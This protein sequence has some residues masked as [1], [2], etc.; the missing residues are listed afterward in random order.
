[1]SA[2]APRASYES[3]RAYDVDAG[4][5]EIQLADNTSPFGTPPAALAAIARATTPALSQYPSTYSRPLREA[6]ARYIGVAPEQVMVGAGSDEVMSCAFR[7]LADPP[8]RVAMIE[9]TFVMARVFAIT[10]SQQVTTVPLREDFDADVE[11]LLA[12][13][14]QLVY[15]CT[16]NNPTGT[17]LTRAAIDRILH[18]SRAVVLLDEAYA[19]YAGTNYAGEAPN[20][21]R[22][23]VLRTFSKAFGMAGFRVGYAVGARPLI[24]ELE[25]ARG[26]YTVSALSEQAALAAVTEDVPWVRAGV[27]RVLDARER[28]MAGLRDA[29][30]APLPSRANFVLLPV[31]GDSADAMRALRERGIQVRHFHGLPGVGEAI[32]ISIGEWPVMQRVLATLQE[33]VPCA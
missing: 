25:K 11:G 2:F 12:A 5:C 3:I 33:R 19:E 26:P 18:E 16:P 17:P 8:A 13:D 10:N 15:L 23:L 28:F 24:A 4:S 14:P 6:I 22:L 21:D 32:R 9:P 7:A 30:Y 20:H 29:G 1:M 27:Q 31:V